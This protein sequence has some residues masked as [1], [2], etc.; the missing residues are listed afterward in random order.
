MKHCETYAGGRICDKP[1][2]V[3]Q[4][5]RL[6]VTPDSNGGVVLHIIRDGF[7]ADFN[8]GKEGKLDFVIFSRLGCRNEPA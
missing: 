6:Q 2:T 5:G 8:F 7:D 4:G 3:E 1:V